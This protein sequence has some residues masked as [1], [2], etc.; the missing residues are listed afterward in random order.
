MADKPVPDDYPSMAMALPEGVDFEEYVIATYF[1][2]VPANMGISWKLA[3]A[4]AIEQSTGTWVAVPGET[5]EVRRRHVAKV[6]S[7]TQIPD[8][9]HERPGPKEEPYRTYVLQIGFPA[10]NV[11]NTLGLLLT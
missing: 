8:Y 11:W 7:V 6:L 2:E 4:I 1:G 3:Q 10:E 9:E 5:P